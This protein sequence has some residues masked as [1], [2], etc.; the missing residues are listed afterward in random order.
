MKKILLLSS[1]IFVSSIS[2]AQQDPQFSQNMYNLLQPNPATAGANDAICASLLYRNQWVDFDRAPKTFLLSVDAPFEILHGG[3]GVTVMADELGYE[4]SINAKL[5]Y[6]LRFDV[7][8]GKIAIGAD[9]GL[10]QKSQKGGLATSGGVFIPIEPNDPLIPKSDVS[11][12]KLDLGAGA[13]YNSEHLYVGFSATHLLEGNVNY[14][15]FKTEVV[16]HLY[17]TI[18]ASL[19]L[20]PSVALKPSVFVKSISA[21]TIADINVN[22]HFNNRFWLGG[23]YRL[24]DAIVIMAGV[25]LVQNLRIGYSYDVTT[26]PIKNYSNGTHEI[27]LGYCYKINKKVPPVIKNVRFL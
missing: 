7:G 17:G 25:T 18:G 1:F 19:D 9:A 21:K 22:V 3:L 8:A 4:K 23:S 27:T 2:F 16:R 5:A 20:T 11:G 26:S 13:F 15:D 12:S 6:A 14:G 24:K 10:L